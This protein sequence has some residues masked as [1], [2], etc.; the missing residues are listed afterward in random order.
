MVTDDVPESQAD[1]G[2]LDTSCET[3][4]THAVP[5][6]DCNDLIVFSLSTIL[7]YSSI[8]VIHDLWYRLP[9]SHNVQSLYPLYQ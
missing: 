5:V 9:Q 4:H 7:S 3:S 6:S 1:V 2:L 8:N